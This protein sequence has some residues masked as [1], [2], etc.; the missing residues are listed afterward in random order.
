MALPFT[1][2]TPVPAPSAVGHIALRNADF[3]GR[4]VD[5]RA[6]ADT[7]RDGAVADHTVWDKRKTAVLQL[8]ALC[9][10]LI[11]AREQSNRTSPGSRYSKPAFRSLVR[12]LQAVAV[13]LPDTCGECL[14]LLDEA[15]TGYLEG[16]ESAFRSDATEQER[17][18]AADSTAWSRLRK[19]ARPI[20]VASRP[21]PSKMSRRNVRPI[22]RDKVTRHDRAR[23]R[24]LAVP[25]VTVHAA[26]GS[27]AAAVPGLTPGPGQRR[28]GPPAEKQR[29]P[30]GLLDAGREPCTRKGNEF[31]CAAVA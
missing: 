4:L 24:S 30:R 26:A 14:A 16:V 21:R 13:L 19:H 2:P 3:A 25:T 23:R 10:R 12:K 6:F 11:A 18:P 20:S 17:D 29:R 1:Q 7:L 28:I 31:L 27:P 15:L 22:G 5:A 9:L 8:H